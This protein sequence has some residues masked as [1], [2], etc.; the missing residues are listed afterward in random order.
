M[1]STVLYWLYSRLIRSTT[2]MCNTVWRTALAFLL[3]QLFPSF[4]TTL[5]HI[6][7]A[8]LGNHLSL[9]RSPDT[10]I[11]HKCS[12]LP[13][14]STAKWLLSEEQNPFIHFRPN[15]WKW[16]ISKMTFWNVNLAVHWH[17]MDIMSSIA[18]AI[19]G[20]KGIYEVKYELPGIW[21]TTAAT[22]IATTGSTLSPIYSPLRLSMV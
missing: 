6:A 9:S 7:S 3:W 20:H 22:V 16:S 1:L 15:I 11:I 5:Y 4:M 17:T 18:N 14:L 12:P 8:I 21:Q 19:F 2:C 10:D 13:Y